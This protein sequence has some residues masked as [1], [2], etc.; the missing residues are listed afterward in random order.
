MI[1][2]KNRTEL[3]QHIPVLGG[4]ATTAINSRPMKGK[5][6]INRSRWKF[7]W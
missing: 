6:S 3:L 2:L 1:R 4:S 7:Q 5:T